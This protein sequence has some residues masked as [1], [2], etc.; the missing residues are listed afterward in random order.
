MKSIE[1]EVRVNQGAV[2]E[3][4]GDSKS[5]T[6]IVVSSDVLAEVDTDGSTLHDD[7]PKWHKGTS[8]FAT[9]RPSH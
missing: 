1:Q 8:V 3:P 9:L 6:A 4:H 2:L 7:P 5:C